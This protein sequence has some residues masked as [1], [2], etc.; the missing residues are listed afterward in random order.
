MP[1]SAI[2]VMSIDTAAAGITCSSQYA[3]R[4]IRAGTNPKTHRQGSP[5]FRSIPFWVSST[6][7]VSSAAITTPPSQVTLIPCVRNRAR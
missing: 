4:A 3:A 6:H 5:S 1:R 7:A 2:S